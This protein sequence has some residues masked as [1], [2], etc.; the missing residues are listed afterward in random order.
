M[1]DPE[2][3]DPNVDH[4][5]TIERRIG[6]GPEHHLT[7]PSESLSDYR[8]RSLAPFRDRALTSKRI[9]LDTRYWIYCRDAMLGN[10]TNPAHVEI[11]E[12]LRHLTARGNVVCPASATILE[13]V[14][15]IGD[16]SR[17]SATASAIDQL[18]G[19][20]AIVSLEDIFT[21]QVYEFLA[22]A[23]GLS[24]Q[25]IV[26]TSPALV[27]GSPQVDCPSLPSSINLAM[28]K[29]SA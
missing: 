3:R 4:F 16:P 24:M 9:Y 29:F 19:G 23:Q 28:N 25:T 8:T 10:N 11:W 20:L 15:R 7:N 21:S 6:Y 18:C 13:E 22:R 17:R 12:R 2:L 26:W 14:C 27:F 1:T 5:V